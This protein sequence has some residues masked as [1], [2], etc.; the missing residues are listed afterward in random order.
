MFFSCN[1]YVINVTSMLQLLHECQFHFRKVMNSAA[2]NQQMILSLQLVSREISVV[3][4][5]FP[6]WESNPEFKMNY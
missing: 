4:E 6:H 5:E 3:R 1:K 2:K